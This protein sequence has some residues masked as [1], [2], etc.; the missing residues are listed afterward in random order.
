MSDSGAD[1]LDIGA[2][3]LGIAEAFSFSQ[4]P[5]HP[6]PFEFGQSLAFA[7]GRFLG[8]LSPPFDDGGA[9]L[10]PSLMTPDRIRPERLFSLQDDGYSDLPDRLAVPVVHILPSLVV[11][12][13]GYDRRAGWT[14]RVAAG[15]PL[16]F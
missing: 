3:R 1:L 16:L 9:R 8:C 15:G 5:L 4:Q 11:Y 2:D 12:G 13:N 10:E 7:P 6:P 14:A